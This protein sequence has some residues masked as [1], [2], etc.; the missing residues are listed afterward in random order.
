MNSHYSIRRVT[1][2]DAGEITSLFR[3]TVLTVNSRD[4]SREQVATWATGADKREKWVIKIQEQYFICA[5]S[6]N[7][8]IGFASLTPEGCLDFMYV[9]KDYQGQ[10][11]AS[12]LYHELESYA[13]EMNLKKIYSQVSITAKPFFEKKGFGVIAKQ[14]IKLGD[15]ELVNYQ[16]EKLLLDS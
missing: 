5:F 4:Y 1:I 7:R 2:A 15:T 10:G 14:D 3:D 9:H 13:V 12:S 6:E 11:V 16:M 8:I